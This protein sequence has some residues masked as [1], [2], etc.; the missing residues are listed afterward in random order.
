MIVFDYLLKNYAP[1]EQR[2]LELSS[3]LIQIPEYYENALKNLQIEKLAP[4][5][6]E[7]TTLMLEG[8]T[9]FLANI[10]QEIQSL[11]NLEQKVCAESY[12]I[13]QNASII[14]SN[15]IKSYLINIRAQL[16]NAKGSFRM[17]K[18]LFLKM[19]V[20][21]EC[22]SL[23]LEDL[24]NLGE[25]DLE[26]N[27]TEFKSVLNKINPNESPEEIIAEIKKNH[28]SKDSLLS[29]TQNMLQ[30]LK[31]FIAEKEF[32]SIPSDVMP[33]VIFTPKP[34]QS[35]AFA[36]MDSPG[37]LEQNVTNCYYYITPPD[38]S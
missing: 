28:P 37:A 7:I 35:Y 21:M 36:N 20:N 12:Q 33:R 9:S 23:S 3:F 31:T 14:A 8:L 26:K 18:E 2:V 10:V 4:E 24:L 15:G 1:L 13:L 6:L 11:E 29:D 27:F 22:I 38:D 5:H 16:P 19:L 34:L 32:V 17:G 30:K 25:K